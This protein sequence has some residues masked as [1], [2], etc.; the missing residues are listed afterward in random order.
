MK[1]K[2]TLVIGAMISLFTNCNSQN[3]QHA[4]PNKTGSV[5]QFKNQSRDG[6]G[7]FYLGREIAQVMGAAGSDWLERSE[8]NEEENTNLAIAN[9][10]LPENAVIADIGA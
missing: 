7:K 6:I 8:R 10:K 2:M 4:A 9:I 3:K 5:Y 1:F